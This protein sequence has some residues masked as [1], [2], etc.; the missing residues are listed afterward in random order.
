M[1]LQMIVVFV[2]TLPSRYLQIRVTWW[3]NELVV[4]PEVNH[5]DGYGL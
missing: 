1:S 2:D 5:G 3:E 4:C